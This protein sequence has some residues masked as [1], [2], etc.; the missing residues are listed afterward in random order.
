MEIT[1]FDGERMP[2][3][4]TH[5]LEGYTAS[6]KQRLTAALTDAIR[7]VVPAP[8]EA[9]TVLLHEYPAEAYARGGQTRQPAPALPNPADLVLAY[10]RAMDARDLDSARAA[11][12]DGFTMVFP[13]T[14][15]L[16][17]LDQLIDWA[18]P[19]YRH[20]TKTIEGV[21]AFQGQ[22]AAVVFTRGT[23]A[24]EWPDGTPF[25]GI[26][27]IDRFEVVGGKITKQDVWNDIAEVRPA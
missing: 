13:G 14:G 24:G 22:G 15:P 5:I 23:L 11:L 19:R 27:F 21:E 6:E 16:H 17:S 20:V 7:F 8:D 12:G 1:D 3:V 4:E 9:I 25:D 10:L 18:K 26:R 2:I